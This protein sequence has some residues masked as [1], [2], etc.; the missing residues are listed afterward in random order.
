MQIRNHPSLRSSNVTYSIADRVVG[1]FNGFATGDAIG[2]QTELLSGEDMLRWYPQGIRGFEGTPNAIIPPI[3]RQF[4]T[5]MANRRNDGR[6]NGHS[7]LPVPSSATGRCRALVTSSVSS[8][9]R[10]VHVSVDDADA[11][12]AH[13][14]C[15]VQL[16]H[17]RS[18]WERAERKAPKRVDPTIGFCVEKAVH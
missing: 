18:R 7:P 16:D 2:K 12:F 5:A 1:C 8:P 3:R 13:R 6:L 10:R 15:G 14:A 9:K 4:E 17:V 11:F